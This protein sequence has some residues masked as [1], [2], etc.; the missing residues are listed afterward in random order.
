MGED[1]AGTSNIWVPSIEAVFLEDLSRLAHPLPT[2]ARENS[3]VR[4]QPD[5]TFSELSDN[6]CNVTRI[7]INTKAVSR[8][9]FGNR[10]IEAQEETSPK[11]KIWNVMERI[12]FT[13]KAAEYRAPIL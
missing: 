6:A 13:P 7:L 1:D 11:V 10:Q 8:R 12:R 9:S 5:S 4:L 3:R 2:S